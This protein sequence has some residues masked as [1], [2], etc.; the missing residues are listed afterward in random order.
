M[1]TLQFWNNISGST[2]QRS[3]QANKLFNVFVLGC[4]NYLLPGVSLVYL[5]LGGS[6][7]KI[8]VAGI[9]YSELNIHKK[10]CNN[11]VWLP[12]YE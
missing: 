8:F 3:F 4:L 10:E 11:T 5:S 6:K 7:R 2:I 12:E 9:I 1:G